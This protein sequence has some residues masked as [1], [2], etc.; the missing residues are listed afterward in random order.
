[1]KTALLDLNLLVALL[2]PSHEH[3]DAA[4]R[5]FRARAN[6]RWATCPLTQLGFVRIVSTPAFSR[7]ALSPANAAALLAENLR[8]PDHEF[9]SESLHVPA[10]IK[11]LEPRL[12]GHRQLTDA[13]LLALARHRKGALATFD[14]RLRDL[15]SET[16]ESAL[17]I[18]PTLRR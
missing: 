8:H 15:A 2:W 3:H 4:H 13:Y 14:R 18:V 5:W 17:E 16:F 10:A 9:W 12:H 6:G 11:E 7:E 1:M